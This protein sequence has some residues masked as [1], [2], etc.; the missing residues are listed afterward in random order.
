MHQGWVKM[1]V[2]CEVCGRECRSTTALDLHKTMHKDASKTETTNLTEEK[3]IIESN[4]ASK[5]EQNDLF[6]EIKLLKDKIEDY[7]TKKYATEEDFKLFEQ[8]LVEI[9]ANKNQEP[10]KIISKKS[11]L[12]ELENDIFN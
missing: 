1:V 2:K 9:I 6:K 4:D 3:N 7:T 8:K 12:D 5:T 11:W 10:K